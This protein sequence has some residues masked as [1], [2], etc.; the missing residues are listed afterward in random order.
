MS[1]ADSSPRKGRKWR[2]RLSLLSAL[3]LMT[4][5]GM[6][7][8]IV[9][10][11]REVGPLRAELRKLR[12]EIGV[13]TIDD[14]LK[15]HAI[16]LRTTEDDNVWKW[17]VW[18]PEGKEYQLNLANSSI[19]AKGFPNTNGMIVLDQQG[20]TWIEYRMKRNADG[21]WSSTLSTP[22]GSIGSS[23]TWVTGGRRSSTSEGVGHETISVPASDKP[24]VLI[25]YRISD[26]GAIGDPAAGFMIWLEPQP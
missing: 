6:G 4:I 13:L 2:P 16:Q 8:V 1:D 3:L 26:T 10:Q 7:C 9:L 14:P 22:E 24:V 20:E 19:S 21:H 23:Q 11:W 15:L 17:R 25:R 18:I 12:N 5:L